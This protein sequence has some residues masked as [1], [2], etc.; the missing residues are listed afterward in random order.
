MIPKP[1]EHVATITDPTA[2]TAF[3]GR[4]QQADWVVVDTEFLRERTYYPQLCLLQIASTDEIGLLDVLALD[5]LSPVATLMTQPQTIKIF[6]AAD[7][8]VEVLQHTLGVMPTPVFDTQIA[9][10]FA[11]LGNQ[12]GYAGMIEQLL[13]LRLPKTQT[14][15]DWSRRPL[16]EQALA[17]AEDDVRYLAVAY[18]M[19]HEQLQQ[20]DRLHWVTADSHALAQSSAQPIDPAA[21]WQRIRSWH[22]FTAAQQQVLAALAQWRE[23]EAMQTNRPRKWVLSDDA[24][25]TLAQ[26]QPTTPAALAAIRNL[27]KKTAQRHASALLDAIH[28]GQQQPAQTLATTPQILTDTQKS[29]LKRARKACNACASDIGIP[30]PM[31]ATRKELEQMACGARDVRALQGWRANL[32]GNAIVDAIENGAN[33]AAPTG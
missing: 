24:L 15:T 1:P 27:P 31:L 29:A 2:L 25:T 30:G 11:G 16:P 17:Y 14:R 21:A 22:R 5:D 13:D 3:I 23:R 6:H 12:I 18:P 7:Q 28:Q 32:A 9:A 19:L 4:M 33:Q 10:A 26:R 20:L 8:D